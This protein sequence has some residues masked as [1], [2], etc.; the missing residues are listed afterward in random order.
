MMTKAEIAK[1]VALDGKCGY[2]ETNKAEFRK[3]STKL[4]RALAANV[5]GKVS[6]NAAGIACSG[7]ASLHSETLHVF[8]NA[9]SGMGLCGRTCKGASDYQ[10]GPNRWFPFSRLSE[11]G[12]DGLVEWAKGI[13]AES[14]EKI[15]V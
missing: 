6:Y 8:F 10:G 12:V 3:L 15:S 5:G 11:T 2:N 9:D 14:T 4:L 13:M 7:D 1:L